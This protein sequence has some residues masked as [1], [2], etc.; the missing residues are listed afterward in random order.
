MTKIVQL[1]EIKHP[2]PCVLTVGTF[3]GVHVGH[4]G[5]IR[6]L[7][8]L[9][10]EEQTCTTIVT[11]DPHPR[12][13]IH[14]DGKKISLL[15]TLQ[16]RAEQLGE[17]GIFR[18]V[19]IPFDR[20]FSLMDSEQFIRST[21]WNRIGVSHFVIGYDH[22]FG[23]DRSGSVDTVMKLGHELGFKTTIFPKQ[24]IGDQAVSSTRIRNLILDSG[25]MERA[26]ELLGRPYQLSG[27][28][29]KGDGR[30]RLLGF[31]TANILPDDER[32]LIP[33]QGVYA[34]TVTSNGSKYSGMLNIGTRPTFSSNMQSIEVNLFDM[35][36]QLYG[37]KLSIDFRFRI[38]DEKTFSS[39]DELVKQL[40]SDRSLSK[41]MLRL[42]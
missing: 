5:L 21:I 24:N 9:A 19:V 1:S 30:G 6:F 7:T 8:D 12:E 39:A 31:P 25:N 38:R 20:D 28:V 37:Q 15:T 17:L 4:I 23:K 41:S 35:D 14:P 29:V 22:H 13:I 32:K 36:E 40:I 3:D 18:L 26:T 2:E 34:V 10:K 11:F 16:E 27:T 42:D 33:K